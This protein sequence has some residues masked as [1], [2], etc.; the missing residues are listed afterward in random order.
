MVYSPG[1]DW[2][3]KIDYEYP[4]VEWDIDLEPVEDESKR[5]LEQTMFCGTVNN[6]FVPGYYPNW[7]D[8]AKAIYDYLK[9]T[10]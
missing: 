2:T 5:T 4:E 10:K 7:N 6:K 1:I 8:A 9:E 3:E